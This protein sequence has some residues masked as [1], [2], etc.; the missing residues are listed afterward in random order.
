MIPRKSRSSLIPRIRSICQSALQTA[1]DVP[2]P[3]AGFI[4]E[5]L[6]TK[7]TPED[8][9]RAVR[10]I[11]KTAGS[12]PGFILGTSDFLEEGTPERNLEVIMETV[13]GG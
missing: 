10:S 8:V 4:R 13:L 5:D 12:R 1:P 2:S 11:L 9:R 3:H 6:L 7:G